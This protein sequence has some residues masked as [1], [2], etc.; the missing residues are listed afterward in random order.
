MWKFF[1]FFGAQI[2]EKKKPRST[3]LDLIVHI[4]RGAG[5]FIFKGLKLRVVM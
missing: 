4:R 2:K 5:L 3:G 1:F